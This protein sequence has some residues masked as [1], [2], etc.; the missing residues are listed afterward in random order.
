[1]KL[2]SFFIIIGYFFGVVAGLGYSFYLKRYEL[3]AAVV[4]LGIIGFPAFK[5]AFK[6]IR[7]EK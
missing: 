2:K 5:Q 6:D 1:M 7:S 4:F 3:V